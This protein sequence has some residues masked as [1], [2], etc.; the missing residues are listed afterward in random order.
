MSKDVKVLKLTTGEEVIGRFKTLNGDLYQLTKA[1]QV[2]MQPVGPQQVGI[3]L[4]PWLASNQDGDVPIKKSQVI[5][6]PI[7][8]PDELEKEYLQQT[9]GIALAK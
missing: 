9:T 4:L 5:V 1:R 2:I 3:G 6:E 7:S 8:P